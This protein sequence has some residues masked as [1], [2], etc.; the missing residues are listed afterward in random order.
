MSH[1]YSCLPT[2]Y[3]KFSLL[4]L[5]TFDSENLFSIIKYLYGVYHALYLNI[6][7]I[8]SFNYGL[9]WDVFLSEAKLYLH[10]ND[11]HYAALSPFLFLGLFPCHLFRGYDDTLPVIGVSLGS[12][13]LW[14]WFTHL[15]FFLKGSYVSGWFYF[16]C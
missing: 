3:K 1:G 8:E 11:F 16:L 4:H 7:I 5:N 9:F 13:F 15:L 2:I 14:Q 10:L 6:W 12:G